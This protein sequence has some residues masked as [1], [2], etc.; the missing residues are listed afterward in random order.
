MLSCR[1]WPFRTFKVYTCIWLCDF[2]QIWS[3][4]AIWTWGYI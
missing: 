1:S 2:L 3:S 4:W